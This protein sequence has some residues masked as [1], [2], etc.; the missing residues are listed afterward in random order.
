MAPGFSVYLSKLSDMAKDMD[1][2]ADHLLDAAQIA[3][4]ETLVAADALGVLGEMSGFPA[5]YRT[6]CQAAVSA[7]SQGGKAMETSSTQLQALQKHYAAKEAYYAKQ[8]GL[9]K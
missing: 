7:F 8:F 3:G 2:A 1:K 9:M 4:G 5:K 6:A